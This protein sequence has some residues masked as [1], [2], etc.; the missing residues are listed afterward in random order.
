[1]K[2]FVVALLAAFTLSSPAF[3]GSIDYD[4]GKFESGKFTG[5]FSNKIT[6]DIIGSLNQI[7]I[8]TGKLIE[9]PSCISG[10]TCFMFTGGSVSVDGGL[11]K[12]TINGG[13]TMK[14]TGGGTISA[15]L[16]STSGVAPGL[17]V[18]DFHFSGN[19][20]TSGSED[21]IPNPVP[22]PTAVSLLGM[23]LVSFLGFLRMKTS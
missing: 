4:T 13:I 2:Q 9:M 1:M 14:A 8:S 19:K 16:V 18:A 7:D 20:I 23:G 5:S 12:G 6:V 11:F 21:V 3:A 15:T 22:E 10:S 17:V